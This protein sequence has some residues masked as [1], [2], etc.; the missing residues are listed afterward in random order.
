M[1]VH[2]YIYFRNETRVN[3]HRSIAG[4]FDELTINLLFCWC[5]TT[6]NVA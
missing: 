1:Q 4:E 3:F 2:S 6:W 5:L